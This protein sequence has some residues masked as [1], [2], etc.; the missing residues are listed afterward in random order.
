MT[1]SNKRID[2][3]FSPFPMEALQHWFPQLT[4]AE[5]ALAA[6]LTMKICTRDSRSYSA[7]RSEAYDD[8]GMNYRTADK[9]MRSL[10]DRGLLAHN[11]GHRGHMPRFAFTKAWY[12]P[13]VKEGGGLP[14]S[15]N[16]HSPKVQT[17]PPAGPG[18]ERVPEA[19]FR[20]KSLEERER[21]TRRSLSLSR[22]RM[23][24][25]SGRTRRR[26]PRQMKPTP[27]QT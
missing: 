20:S 9:A 21:A 26:H 6:F 14:L 16:G 23:A 27:G 19:P 15:A 1:N 24:P 12:H 10:V 2:Y 8:A 3:R 11:D 7:W 22:A 13:V 5:R 4:L 25:P 17:E 18:P